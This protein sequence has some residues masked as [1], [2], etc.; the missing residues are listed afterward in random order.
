LSWCVKYAFSVVIPVDK[1]QS[2]NAQNSQRNMTRFYDE[3]RVQYEEELEKWRKDPRWNRAAHVLFYFHSGF[4][5]GAHEILESSN[6]T[7]Q[8]F[9]MMTSHLHLHHRLEDTE[10]YPSLIRKFNI[11]IALFTALENDHQIIH[12]TEK[13]VYLLLKRKDEGVKQVMHEFADLLLT[14]LAKE[15]LLIMPYLL[16]MRNIHD[17]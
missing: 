7:L 4:R 14:H 1:S 8:Q 12:D 9:E 17:W 15:E 3:V 10:F 16:L 5:Q 6:P 2:S 11:D 13:Q